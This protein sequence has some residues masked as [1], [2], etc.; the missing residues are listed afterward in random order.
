MK[1]IITVLSF[2]FSFNLF[3]T[4]LPK[5][6]PTITPTQEQIFA[7]INAAELLQY[8]HYNKL[9]LDEELSKVIF[10]NYIKALDYNRVLFCATDIVELEKFRTKLGKLTISGNLNPIYAMYRVYMLRAKQQIEFV[11]N[12][13]ANGIEN[14][15]FSSD[16]RLN[17]DREKTPRASDETELIYLWQMLLKDEILRLKL[18]KKSN[19]EIT[20][21]LTKRYNN[22][23]KLL[24]QTKSEDVFNSYMNSVAHAYDPHTEYLSPTSTESFNINMSLSLQGIGAQLSSDGEYTKVVSLIPAGPAAKSGELAPLDRIIGVGQENQEIQDIVG[25]RL[26]DV[27]KLIRGEKGSKV[28]LDVIPASNVVGDETSKQVVLVRDA[29]KLEDQ[30]ASKHVFE[31]DNHKIGLIRIPSFYIDFEAYRA[32]NANYTSTTRDVKKL[33]SELMQE[34]VQAVVIDLRD[35][36]GGSLQEASELTSLFVGALPTVL[37]KNSRGSV[38][39]LLDNTNKKPFYTGPLTILINRHSASASEIFAGAMQD[40]HRGLI[41]GSPTFGKGTVQAVHNLNYGNLKLTIAKFYR[42]SGNST[43]H[44]GVEPD[45][46]FLPQHNLTKIGESSLDR[47]LPWDQIQPIIIAKNNHF[48]NFLAKLQKNHD[49][50]SKQNL[51]FTYIK[52]Y[53][54]LIAELEQNNSVSLNEKTRSDEYQ[55]LNIRKLELENLKRKAQNKSILTEIKDED[56]EEE[57]LILE[58]NNKKQIDLATDAYLDESIKVTIDYLTCTNLFVI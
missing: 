30:A 14:I 52:K 16:E 48:A 17:L 4:E 31:V 11:K 43:Q 56:D 53:K 20:N 34:K 35:N 58:Q 7:S 21:I 41:V 6:L 18:A 28:T 29:I 33:L 1:T 23:L 26:D 8:H 12:A 10:D 5:D 24:F 57:R 40:Y 15:D 45:I 32:G 54:D 50:R 25:W 36:G 49:V 37:V 19:S 44:K 9:K 22:R 2:I 39:T 13:L 42:V 3:A 46:H 38:D 51:E 27:V 55:K 47:A